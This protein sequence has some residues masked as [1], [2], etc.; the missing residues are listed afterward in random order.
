MSYL[1]DK[2]N[3]LTA[4]LPAVPQG[5]TPTNAAANPASPAANAIP[6]TAPATDAEA[7]LNALRAQV[8][9]LQADNEA[10]QAK[11]KEA[12]RMQPATVDAQEL[13]RVQA[14]V[15]SLM[16]ENDLF[17]ARLSTGATT[18]NAP[19]ELLKLRQAL[20]DANKK[21]AEQTHAAD[22]LARE[23]QTLQSA[24]KN[25]ALDKAAL[26]A[27]LRQRQ[28]PAVSEPAVSSDE[29]KSLRARLAV[30]EAQAQRGEV[31]ARVCRRQR[32]RQHDLLQLA[33]PDPRQGLGHRLRVGGRG[34]LCLPAHRRDRQR[35]PGGRRN[36]LPRLRVERARR[37][38]RASR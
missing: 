16:K 9:N 26:E 19:G 12:L 20:T 4:Q 7:Q 27:R 8:Q 38:G 30:D 36:E 33:G 23:N 34:R 21:L 13:A 10:L 6:A 37:R 29:V 3:G 18:G 24:A 2:V 28:T 14:Q 5:A 31:D 1:A 25:N 32:P 35:G 15:L 11:L 17:R 22:K